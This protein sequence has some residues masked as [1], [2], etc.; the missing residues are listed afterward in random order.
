MLSSLCLSR[1]SF[2]AEGG[3]GSEAQVEWRKRREE[4]LSLSLLHYPNFLESSSLSLS[5]D[6]LSSFLAHP[7]PFSPPHRSMQSAL[8]STRGAAAAVSRPLGARQQQRRAVVA[9]RANVSCRCF[10]DRCLLLERDNERT[11]SDLRLFFRK[12]LGFARERAATAP[13]LCAQYRL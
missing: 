12:P 8:A 5:H 2:S 7:S 1:G 11:E 9:A 6:F 10:V 4:Q 13:R 3:K